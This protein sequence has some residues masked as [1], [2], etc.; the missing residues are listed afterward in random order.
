[1][2]KVRLLSGVLL[3]ALCVM[4]FSACGILGIGQNNSPPRSVT[5]TLDLNGGSGVSQLVYV[6]VVSSAME[7]PVPVREGYTFDNWY[8]RWENMSLTEFPG[9]DMTF[10][11]RYYAN[12]DSDK[13]LV[14]K[15]EVGKEYS[16]YNGV[17][18]TNSGDVSSEI[19]N[20]LVYL[21]ENYQSAIKITGEVET[22]ATFS[23]Y[24]GFSFRIYGS[25]NGDLLHTA[26]AFAS[27][28]Y[29]T[30]TFSFNTTAA[31]I[32]GASRIITIN[33]NSLNHGVY[34]NLVFNI[35]YTELAGT[36]V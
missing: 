1:M 13:T 36:L 26:K 32:T 5:V 27:N 9:S 20:Q 28:T 15:T 8:G 17:T 2:K 10:T 19:K 12:S 11:A 31:T 16:S 34:R 35:N 21:K 18:F 4:M 29:A 24:N 6:G 3:A 30:T 22:R 25:S 23:G 33:H 14:L 7:L